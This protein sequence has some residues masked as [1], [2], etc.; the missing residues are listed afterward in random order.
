MEQE[1]LNNARLPED[2]EE[3]TTLRNLEVGEETWTVPWAMNIDAERRC[4]LSAGYAG[5]DEPWGTVT[6]L[7]RREEEGFVVEI[8]LSDDYKWH[9][10]H[11]LTSEDFND[12]DPEKPDYLPVIR[13]VR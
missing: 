10:S 9:I 8:D 3:G 12:Q 2:L 4:W 13:I 6:M 11:A 1:R 5:H 7:V